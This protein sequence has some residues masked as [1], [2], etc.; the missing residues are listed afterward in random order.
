MDLS[1][2]ELMQAATLTRFRVSAGNPS[3]EQVS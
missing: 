1:R 2:R 3:V